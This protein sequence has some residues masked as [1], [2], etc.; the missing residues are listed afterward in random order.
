MTLRLSIYNEEMQDF[1]MTSVSAPKSIKKSELQE[2]IFRETEIPPE[3][4]R[5]LRESKHYSLHYVDILNTDTSV[6]DG[7]RLYVESMKGHE[8]V[9]SDRYGYFSQS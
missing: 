6:E 1:R 4:Q 2:L 5:I 3:E 7:Q 8:S 9:V